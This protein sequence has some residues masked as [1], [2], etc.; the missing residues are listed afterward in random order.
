[1]TSCRD[2][3]PCQSAEAAGLPPVF[4]E[5]VEKV[6]HNET[7]P[8]FETAVLGPG[9]VVWIGLYARPGQGTRAWLVV[10]PDGQLR[11]R[12]DLSAGARVLAVR[13]DRV[14]LVQRDELDVEDFRVYAY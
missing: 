12:M 13:A 11:G 1:M 14:A 9:E 3:G 8:A 5:I 7:F 4:V 6:P 2:S 10:G